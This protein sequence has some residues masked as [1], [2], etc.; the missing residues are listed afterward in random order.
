[1]RLNTASTRLIA[2]SQ[3]SAT[4]ASWEPST[5]RTTTAIAHETMP[6]AMLV[7]G[8][9]NAIWK[10][11]RGVR[12]SPSKRD[13]PPNSQSVMSCTWI[14]RRRAT[15]EWLSSWASSEAR[16]NTVV[17]RAAIQYSPVR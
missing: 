3:N 9:A 5:A 11:P 6:I 4:T 8:P 15:T 1:M 2:P 14:P 16:N 10:S 17:K 12:A 7:A 13:T